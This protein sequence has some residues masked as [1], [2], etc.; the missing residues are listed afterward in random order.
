MDT[1][2]KI[3]LRRPCVLKDEMNVSLHLCW[4]MYPSIGWPRCWNGSSP[5][6]VAPREGFI[7]IEKEE[8][9]YERERLERETSLLHH[10]YIQNLLN[11]QKY[12][13]L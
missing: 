6:G 2:Q 8:G 5:P 1:Q 9:C 7:N 13:Y 11:K 4:N 12:I 3:I 10:L